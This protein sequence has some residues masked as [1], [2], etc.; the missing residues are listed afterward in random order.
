MRVFDNKEMGYTF[1]GGLVQQFSPRVFN[2]FCSVFFLLRDI[3]I[4]VYF[5]SFE[6]KKF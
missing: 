6:A 5:F 1:C 4:S 3:R 2:I